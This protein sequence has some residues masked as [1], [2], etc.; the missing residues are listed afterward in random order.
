MIKEKS[1][2]EKPQNK[3]VNMTRVKAQTESVY[4]YFE[5]F[6]GHFTPQNYAV[7]AFFTF[8]KNIPHQCK[9]STA[10]ED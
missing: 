9:H 8:S 1:N 10:E 2:T 6:T 5:H 4:L 7:R 3:L